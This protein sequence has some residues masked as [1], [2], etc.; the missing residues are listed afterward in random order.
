MLSKNRIKHLQSLSFKKNRSI[1]KE[2]IAEGEKIASELLQST[3]HIKAIYASNQWLAKNR[4]LLHKI[5][6][7][8]ET[9]TDELKK[10]SN[11]SSPNEVLLLCAIPSYELKAEALK[12]QL[13]IVLDN[14]RDPGNLGTIIR[15]ADWFGI[16]NI[17]CSEECADCFNPKVVQAT[18]GS[19]TRIKLHYVDL[20]SF[21][22][23]LSKL[24]DIPI[25]GAL[26]NG[27]NIYHQKLSK[28][29]IIMMGNES[30]GISPALIPY[31]TQALQI[32]SFNLN[33]EIDSLNVAMATAIICSEFKRNS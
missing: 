19:I 32:P 22:K 29:G 6:E 4:Q 16:E 23:N 3:L 17:I 12:T 1:H 11:L 7:I 27:K 15:L 5:T 25:Y 8:V 21:F 28:H 24:N 20:A 13:S 31:I 10:I 14:V 30:K 2:F 18:M 9:S 33:S 26:L